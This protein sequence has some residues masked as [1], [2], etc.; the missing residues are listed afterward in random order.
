MSTTGIR[1]VI[2]TN[3]FITI[4]GR[5]SPFRWIFDALTEGKLI[6]CLS[7]EII[8]EYQEILLHKTNEDVASNIVDF[9]TIHPFVIKS[10][11]YFRFMLIAQDMDDNKFVDCAI[12]ANAYCIV[13]NDKHFNI[14]EK[15]RFPK[16]RGLD[17]P[18][19]E[20]LFKKKFSR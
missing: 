11:P 20:T 14:L 13:S 1:V 3:V 10:E 4:I 12:A 7:G 8:L 9:L 6:L 5:R 17:L 16:V 18:E 19:F 2:D 15:I